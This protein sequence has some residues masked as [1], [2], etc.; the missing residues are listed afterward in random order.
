MRVAL[1]AATLYYRQHLTMGAIADDLGVS[2]SSVSRLL[3]YARATGLIEIR[4]HAPQE[5]RSRLE[6]RFAEEFGV[7]AY[8]VPGSPR[9]PEH[10]RLE[11]T[12]QAAAQLIAAAVL[13]RTTLGVAWGSTTST[14]ARNLPRKPVAETRV[15]QMNGAAN[16][17][18]SGVSYTTELLGGF[19]DAFASAVFEFPVPAIFD[20]PATR[21]ALW[22]ERAVSRVIDLQAAVTLFVFGLGSRIG[23]PRS[24]IY[25]G[26]YLGDDDLRSLVDDSV[27]GDCATVFYRADGSTDGI[28]M[29]ARSSGPRFDVVRRIPH[30]LCVVSGAAKRDSLRGA[31]AAG[32]ITDLV[33]DERLARLVLAED[34]PPQ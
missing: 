11:R 23:D 24:H 30:R 17:L 19:A 14:V 2:R 27:V 28:A 29:N 5:A 34:A 26:G 33:V 16:G 10:E 9:Q 21:T 6:Q 25:S 4:L 20:D 18:T 7:T 15:V 31:L 3:Q 1:R 32:I 13:P 8:V 22:R 12:A